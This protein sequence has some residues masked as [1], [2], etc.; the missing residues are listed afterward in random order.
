M[1]L[2]LVALPARGI[3]LSTAVSIPKPKHQ[4]PRP[5]W[6]LKGRTQKVCRRS[7]QSALPTQQTCQ[8]WCTAYPQTLNAFRHR[9]IPLADSE[10]QSR[11]T[12]RRMAAASRK[13]KDR[14]QTT[15]QVLMFFSLAAPTKS[16]TCFLLSGSG[17]RG[18]KQSQP[19]RQAHHKF[20]S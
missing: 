20:V 5:H 18:A 13:C 17:G 12:A 10:E 8:C 16:Q 2:C 14:E 15:R 7:L 11:K 1:K 3:P 6:Q 9:A 19:T 4:G